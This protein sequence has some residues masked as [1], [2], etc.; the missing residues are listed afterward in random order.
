MYIIPD[1]MQKQHT[2][3]SLMAHK[4]SVLQSIV[5]SQQNLSPPSKHLPAAASND[6]RLDLEVDS[7]LGVLD[8]R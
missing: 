2:H 4:P 1:S 7:C 8:G 3:F 5:W 6:F